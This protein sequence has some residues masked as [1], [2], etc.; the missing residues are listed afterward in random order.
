M[1]RQAIAQ[2]ASQG[3]KYTVTLYRDELGYTYQGTDCGGNIGN[4]SGDAAAIESLQAMVDVGYFQADA[5][6]TG[7]HRTF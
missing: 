5:N 1:E 3:K 2:W 6:T 7:M 4:R